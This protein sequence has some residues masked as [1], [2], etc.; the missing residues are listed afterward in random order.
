MQKETGKDTKV[1]CEKSPK[2]MRSDKNV[3]NRIKWILVLCVLAASFVFMAALH[4][5]LGI[6]QL[7]G[8]WIFLS[9]IRG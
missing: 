2:F 9:R 8:V 4:I 1:V 7:R 5:F 3:G 6:S